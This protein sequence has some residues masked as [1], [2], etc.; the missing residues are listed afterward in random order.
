MRSRV[1]ICTVV[2]GAMLVVG[3]GDPNAASLADAESRMLT[4]ANDLSEIVDLLQAGAPIYDYEPAVDLND[5][6][7]GRTWWSPVRSSG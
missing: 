3:C 1:A 6:T 4:C 5:R 2:A 7:S